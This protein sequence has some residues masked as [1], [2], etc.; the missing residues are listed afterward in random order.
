VALG[1]HRNLVSATAITP[2]HTPWNKRNTIFIRVQRAAGLAQC[3]QKLLELILNL[4]RTLS[5]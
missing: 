2:N 1:V 3:Q 4:A 5:T